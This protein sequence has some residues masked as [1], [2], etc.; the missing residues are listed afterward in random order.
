[1]SAYVNFKLAL[2]WTASLNFSILQYP[3]NTLSYSFVV[4]IIFH[5]VWKLHLRDNYS[6]TL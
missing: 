4:I 6:E 3:S 5:F 2:I 1:M